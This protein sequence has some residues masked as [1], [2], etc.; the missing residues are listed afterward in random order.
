MS[1]NSKLP[2]P[3]LTTQ[4]VSVAVLKYKM[5]YSQAKIANMLGVSSM[6]VSRLLDSAIEHGIVTISVKTPIDTNEELSIKIK[7]RYKLHDALIVK[8]N[9]Y[10]DSITSVAKGTAFY[11]DLAICPGDVLGIAAGRTLSRVMPYMNLPLIGG[12]SKGQFEVIQ[13]QGGYTA[14]GD[15]NP[16]NSIINF[17]NRFGAKGH[18]L[19]HPMYESSLEM[20]KM[21]YEHEMS[22]LEEMW[23]RCS[24]LVSGVGTWGPHSIQREEGLLSEKDFKELE[25]CQVVGDLFGRWFDSN[26]QYVNC[27][28]NKRLVSIP[29]HVQKKVPKRILVSSGEEKLQ[30]IHLLL[31]NSMMNILISDEIS[32]KRLVKY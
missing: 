23:S 9:T 20:A 5:G 11:L 21:T 6:T 3:G 19:Q 12:N 31:K 7:E 30:A 32:A 28:C 17:S 24:I 26:G 14:M 22:L 29:P 16:T 1:E 2:K 27:S 8:N 4:L 18:L 25:E 10:E 15:R 13:L